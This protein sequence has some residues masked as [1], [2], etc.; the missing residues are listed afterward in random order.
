M[1]TVCCRSL[2]AF[3]NDVLTGSSDSSTVGFMIK[4]KR[5][6]T[7]LSSRAA[8]KCFVNSS[9]S[10]CRERR[11]PRV[12]IYGSSKLVREK[13]SANIHTAYGRLGSRSLSAVVKGRL[14]QAKL[15]RRENDFFPHCTSHIHILRSWIESRSGNGHVSIRTDPDSPWERKNRRESRP[16]HIGKPAAMPHHVK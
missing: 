1:A 6:T 11:R 9:M 2:T 14:I 15:S 16:V 8:R 10:L 12:S 7:L 4:Q 5:S 3:S 13:W